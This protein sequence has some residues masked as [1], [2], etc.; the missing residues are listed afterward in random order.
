[1]SEENN[2]DEFVSS[3]EKEDMAIDYDKN[4]INYTA[5]STKDKKDIKKKVR[6]ILIDILIYAAIIYSCL[7]LIPT[8]VIQRTVVD[9]PSMENTLHNEEQLMVEKVSYHF[10]ALGRFDII[11]FYP[12]GRKMEEYYVKRIIGLPGETIQIIDSDIYINGEVLNE[13]YGKDPITYAGIAAE[14]LTLGEDE[15]FVMGD[16]REVSFDSRYEEVGVVNK[17]NIG[18]KALLRIWPF[19]KFGLID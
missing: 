19:A 16:N 11:V 14:P 18:G 4:N 7:Y 15:Y 2:K 5:E 3:E 8:Y 12:Y 6:T 10:D 17:R 1:M 9:G 13:N